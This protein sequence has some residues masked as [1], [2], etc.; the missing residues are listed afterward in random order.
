VKLV[1]DIDDRK[2]NVQQVVEENGFKF[3]EHKVTT[4]DGYILTVHRIVG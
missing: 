3:E 2:H 4:S 1:A